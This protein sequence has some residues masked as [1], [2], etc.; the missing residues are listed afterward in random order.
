MV[1]MDSLPLRSELIPRLLLFVSLRSS[2][3]LYIK[4]TYFFRPGILSDIDIA[5]ADWFID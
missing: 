1:S 2:C 4:S 5:L 3:K